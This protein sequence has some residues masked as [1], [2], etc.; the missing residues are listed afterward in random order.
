MYS[1]LDKSLRRCVQAKTAPLQ[2]LCAAQASAQ[3]IS[4]AAGQAASSA[5][6]PVFGA[7]PCN[8]FQGE[9]IPMV[10]ITKNGMKHEIGC[11][12]F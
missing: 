11:V 9:L 2:V 10:G 3:A 1:A 6:S 12:D 5:I 7:D 4:N 8:L